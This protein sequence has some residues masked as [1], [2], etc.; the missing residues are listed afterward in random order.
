MAAQPRFTPSRAARGVSMSVETV[1]FV[2]ADCALRPLRDQMIVE[3]LDVVHSRILIV[4][5]ETKPLRGTVRAVGPGCYPKRYDH[6]DKAKRTKMWDS[7]AFRPTVT[8]VGDIVQLGGIAWGG[9]AFEGFFWGDTY[10]IHCREEDV[11]GI[12]L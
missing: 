7:M 6:P 12:E 4:Y 8:R 9:F 5:V 3:P 11:C 2:P 1:D 10:C